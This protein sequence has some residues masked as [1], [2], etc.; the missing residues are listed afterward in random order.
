M[1]AAHSSYLNSNIVP[2]PTFYK[3]SSIFNYLVSGN[4]HHFPYKSVYSCFRWPSRFC[5]S[6]KKLT[7]V[8]SH[9]WRLLTELI[10]PPHNC[11]PL[12]LD[13]S[14]KTFVTPLPWHHFISVRASQ[15]CALLKC[16]AQ[17]SLKPA[18]RNEVLL[19]SHLPHRRCSY[20]LALIHLN[21]FF[22]NTQQIFTTLYYF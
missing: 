18:A 8:Y 6:T 13:W 22:T 15:H 21:V 10:R 11:H 5:F 3:L 16:A 12:L 4:L 9:T 2:T 1:T 20:N 14:Q 7:I 19:F 17:Y